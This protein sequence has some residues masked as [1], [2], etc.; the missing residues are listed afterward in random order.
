M[1][2]VILINYFY[3]GKTDSSAGSEGSGEVRQ[4][5]S[6]SEA[7]TE[8]KTLSPTEK[9]TK[10]PT[11]PVTEAPTEPVTEPPTAPPTEAPT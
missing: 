3:P 1:A 9:E 11:E 7:P 8:A 6:F 5:T 2:G 10:A 4:G